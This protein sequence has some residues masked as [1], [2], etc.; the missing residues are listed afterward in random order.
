MNRHDFT[1]QH[2]R[3]VYD[4]FKQKVMQHA[5]AGKIACYLVSNGEQHA[6]QQQ[7]ADTLFI[8]AVDEVATELAIELQR[9]EATPPV[10]DP[11]ISPHPEEE[12][13]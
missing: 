2:Q 3:H 12:S 9:C 7:T 6:E 13:E 10:G 11:P 5:D 4:M 1:I 8:A